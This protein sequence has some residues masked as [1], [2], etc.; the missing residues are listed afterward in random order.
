[1]MS[2][3]GQTEVRKGGLHMLLASFWP[4]RILVNGTLYGA[5]T[6]QYRDI[7]QH[8]IQSLLLELK[9]KYLLY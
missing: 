9:R 5:R 6:V 4:W 8:K 7:E 2:C 3:S 1:M